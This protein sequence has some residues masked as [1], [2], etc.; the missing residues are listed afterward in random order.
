[1]MHDVP[2]ALKIEHQ[3]LREQLESAAAAGGRT[4]EAAQGVLKV[5]RPHILLEEEFAIPPLTLLPRLARGEVASD[6]RPYL[7]Q[8]E[9]LKAELPRMLQEHGLIVEALRGLMQAAQEE[10]HAGFAL[11]AK[12]MIL[13]AQ[14]EEE[15]LYPASILVG[16][17][18]RGRLPKA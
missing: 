7:K 2:E 15:I 4:G 6:M 16:E 18:L 8:S 5:L 9:T 1:M 10:G 17:Y 11:F 3:E 14:T 12:K 13:H